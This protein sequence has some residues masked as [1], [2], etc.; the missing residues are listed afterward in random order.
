MTRIDQRQ[1]RIRPRLLVL[2]III[3]LAFQRA[4]VAAPIS[5]SSLAAPHV[6][7]LEEVYRQQMNSIEELLAK[8]ATLNPSASAPISGESASAPR[9]TAIPTISPAP[10]PTRPQLHPFVAPPSTHPSRIP[11]RPGLP[12]SAR[13][14]PL[15]TLCMIVKNEAHSIVATLNSVLGHVDRYSILDTGSTDGTLEI[16]RAWAHTHLEEDMFQLH[17]GPFV[18]FS[19]T[20]NEA[21]RLARA[22]SEFNLVLNGDDRL[23]DGKQ[24]RIWLESKRF[25]RGIAEEMYI[26]PISY[27]GITI[28]RSERVSRSANHFVPNWPN[29][30]FNHWKYEGVTHEVYVSQAALQGGVEILYVPDEGAFGIYHDI[31]FDTQEAK[32]SRFELDIVLLTKELQEQEKRQKESGGK[33]AAA[34]NRPRSMYYLAQSYYNLQRYKEAFHWFSERL[35]VDYPRPTPMGRDNERSKAC[36]LMALMGA[37]QL[38]KKTSELE[39]LMERA[40]KYCPSSFGAL[41]MGKFYIT[42]WQ[43][44]QQHRKQSPPD[45]HLKSKAVKFARLS[46]DYLVNR[47]TEQICGDDIPMVTRQLPMLFEALGLKI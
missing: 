31:T 46:H 1:H 47:R 19:T 28:G 4:S 6:V 24:M 13:G 34:P 27:G 12:V 11:S 23:V 26:V 42:E 43:K 20:R 45:D 5:S 16:M 21:L 41:Q 29:D 15:V 17:E 36:S 39:S 25:L 44:Q 9:A 35:K 10:A 18:D 40:W 32:K 7:V 2:G 30:A 33:A 3:I 38:G 14:K 22:E 8:T 37:T